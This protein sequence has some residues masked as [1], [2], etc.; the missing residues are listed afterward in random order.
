MFQGSWFYSSCSRFTVIIQKAENL[1]KVRNS[2]GENV[3][4]PIKS[5][6]RFKGVIISQSIFRLKENET[7]KRCIYRRIFHLLL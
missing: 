7:K 6:K 5:L 2:G 4:N 3:G 1:K